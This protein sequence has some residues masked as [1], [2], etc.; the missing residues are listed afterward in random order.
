[1][2][3][4]AILF[5]IL[6]TFLMSSCAMVAP[7][8]GTIYTGMKAGS[9]ENSDIQPAKEGQACAQSVLGIITWGDASIEAA[10]K[11]GSIKKVASVDHESFAVLVYGKYCTV[12]KGE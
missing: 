11:D 5:A 4:T 2:K 7:M 8:P 6:A 1:M 10:K 3:K 9:F 12:V